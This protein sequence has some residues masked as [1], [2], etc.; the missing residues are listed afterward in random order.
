MARIQQEGVTEEELKRVKTQA[1]AAQVFKRDSLMAQAM[2]IGQIEAAGFSW[3]DIDTLIERIRSVSAEEVQAVA[4]KYF[5]DDTLTVA[6]LD[7][8]PLDAAAK[9]PRGF[10]TRH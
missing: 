6:V 5:G 9:R 1:I 3:R 10:A 4:K 8:Q 2:E 7:P